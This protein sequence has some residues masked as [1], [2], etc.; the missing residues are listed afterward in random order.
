M[1][2][3]DFAY[4]L[5]GYFEIAGDLQSSLTLNQTVC[6]RNHI[7]LVRTTQK[8]S[9]LL[10]AIEALLDNDDTV[11]IRKVISSYFEHVIDP[12]HPNQEAANTAHS[13]WSGPG[14]NG[15]TMRC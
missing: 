11:S 4:W 12:Q 13:P 5:Q 15:P 6:I 3:R 2:E 7:A 9:V 10:T 1:T 8:T 14:T